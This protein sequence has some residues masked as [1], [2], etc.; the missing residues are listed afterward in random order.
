MLNENGDLDCDPE[1]TVY[2]REV[3]EFI[4]CETDD[5][6]VES[7][8]HEDKCPVW[9]DI[10]LTG[11]EKN[12]TMLSL[13]CS[14]RCHHDEKRMYYYKGGAQPFGI[15]SPTLPIGWKEGDKFKIGSFQKA[16][17]F[18]EDQHEKM[19]TW[20]NQR[21]DPTRTTPVD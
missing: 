10:A 16:I 1:F 17:A 15:K 2:H 9:I 14:G 21:V 11:A 13:S 18:Y 19:K 8:F 12:R 4:I 3:G 20:Q 7:I 6:V 5:E